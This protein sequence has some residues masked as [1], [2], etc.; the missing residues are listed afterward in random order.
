MLL[1]HEANGEVISRSTVKAV[2]KSDNALDV[3]LAAD[4]AAMDR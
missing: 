4:I 1:D 3:R 2:T